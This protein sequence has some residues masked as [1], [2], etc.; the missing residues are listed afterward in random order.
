MLIAFAGL[1]SAGKSTTAKA[2]A[3]TLGVR[4]FV[5]PEEDQWPPAVTERKRVGHFTALT[6]FRSVRVPLL[7]A[8]A[9][10]AES[11]GIAVIDS[12]YDVLIS[13]YIGQ[14]PFA[15]LLG[16]DDPYFAVAQQMAE[17]D[18]AGLPH[19]D[20]LVFLRLE[21]QVWHTFMDRRSRTLDRTAH[22]KEQFAMQSL[23][24]EACQQAKRE[25]GSHLIVVDQQDS[26]PAATAERVAAMLPKLP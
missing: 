15:W 3:E 16:P 23:M 17:L 2:L 10:A 14:P 6:W 25:H 12:Y 9:A 13:R 26:S 11:E 20:V 5:E 19:A 21:A 24:E 22:L 8:A 18:W 7:Y 4:W 1:P